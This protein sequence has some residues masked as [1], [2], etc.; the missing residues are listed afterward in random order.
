MRYIDADE[1]LK[2]TIPVYGAYDDSCEFEAVPVGYVKGAPTADVA[3][4]ARGR[5]INDDGIPGLYRCSACGIVDHREPKHRYCPS[6]GARM[7]AEGGGQA[8]AESKA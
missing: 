7:D 4:V 5:W 6:C 8:H 3:P 2:H 1:L